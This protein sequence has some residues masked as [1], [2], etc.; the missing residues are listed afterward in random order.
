MS[1]QRNEP[2]VA[3]T[4]KI[5]KRLY[6]ALEKETNGNEEAISAFVQAGIEVVLNSRKDPIKTLNP[7]GMFPKPASLNNAAWAGRFGAAAQLNPSPSNIAYMRKHIKL[8]Q[9]EYKKE[10]EKSR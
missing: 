8:A 3:F 6:D 1:I 5:S 2:M 7:N 4:T 10:M 9:E